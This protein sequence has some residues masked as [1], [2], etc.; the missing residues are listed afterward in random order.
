[1]EPVGNS[2]LASE[3]NSRTIVLQLRGIKR[4]LRIILGMAIFCVV[5]TTILLTLIAA[6]GWHWFVTDLT[7][8]G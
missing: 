5:L 1:M 6:A 7:A 8:F 2:S 3:E 4:S